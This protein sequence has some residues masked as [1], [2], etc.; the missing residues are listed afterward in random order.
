MVLM[1]SLNQFS[2]FDDLGCLLQNSS[3]PERPKPLR[4][5]FNSSSSILCPFFSWYQSLN[6]ASLLISE[7][8]ICSSFLASASSSAAYSFF[9]HSTSRRIAFLSYFAFAAL[10]VSSDS[11]KSFNLSFFFSSFS[12]ASNTLLFLW[13]AS[14][15]LHISSINI[16]VYSL[17][18]P[19]RSGCL[20]IYL[21][22]SALLNICGY[23]A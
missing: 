21:Y 19:Y 5:L 11:F 18:S 14:L 16:H 3:H 20:L 12:L 1:P 7:R 10:I 8:Y 23:T 6:S 9:I 15:Y 17:L 2:R 22:L 4:L 13:A